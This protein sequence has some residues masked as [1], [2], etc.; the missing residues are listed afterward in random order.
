MTDEI[1][2]RKDGRAGRVTLKRPQALNALTWPMVDALTAALPDLAADPD[3]DLLMIDAEGDRAFCSGGDIAGI[4]KALTEGDHDTPR[5]FWRDEYPL[6]AALF[7]FPKP[8]VT[9]LQGF[10]MGGG[11]G[12]GCHGSHRIVDDSS[13]IAMPECGIGLIPDVGGSLLLGRAPGRIG[14]YLGLTG[15]RMDA[16]DAIF[17]GFADYY[18]PDGWEALKTR[19]AETGDVSEVDRAAVTPP[20]SRLAGWQSVIDAHFAGDTLGDIMRGLPDPLPEPLAHATKLMARNAP[21]AMGCALQVIRRV[22]GLDTIE[23]ALDQEFRYTFR[24]P[25]QGDFQEGIRAAIIDKDR[26]PRWR[27]ADWKALSNA[28]VTRMI[29]PLGPDTLKLERTP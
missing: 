19:L 5:R 15:D 13:R 23:G 12:I 27:H 17:A 7:H 25:E 18:L 21:L 1:H 10:T 9:F 14:E 22:R 8:V 26:A 3:V 28:E 11:V 2:I 6:N 4:Y 16:A 20:D 24:A 29:L